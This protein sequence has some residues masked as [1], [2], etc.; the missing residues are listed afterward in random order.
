M[1]I[2][3]PEL[4]YGYYALEPFIDEEAIKTGHNR[5]NL[6][7]LYMPGIPRCNN[8][9]LLN[10]LFLNGKDHRHFIA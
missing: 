7:L 10:I 1:K 3:L 8:C 6:K 2:K 4:G 9:F 5:D